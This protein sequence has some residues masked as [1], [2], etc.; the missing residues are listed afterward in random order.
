[1]LA[2]FAGKCVCG[3]RVLPGM[4]VRWDREL[5]R[6]AGCP[7]CQ[8]AAAPGR[9]HPT[10]TPASVP[11][12]PVAVLDDSELFGDDAPPPIPAEQLAALRASLPAP[13]VQTDSPAAASAAQAALD[14]LLARLDPGQRRVA[15]WSPAQGNVRVIA[16]AGSGKTTTTTALVGSVIQRGV[17]PAAQVIATTFT[18]RAGKELSERLARVL[19]P[20]QHRDLRVGTF[21]GLALRAL[22][23]SSSS[24]WAMGRCLDIGKRDHGV[25]SATKLWGMVLGW[26]EIPGIGRKGLDLGEDISARDYAQVADCLRAGLTDIDHPQAEEAARIAARAACLQKFWDAWQL[27]EEAKAAL[28]AWDFAD[29]LAEWHA[30]LSEDRMQHRAQLVVVDEAQDNSLI[31]LSIAQQLSRDGSLIIV[32]DCRQAIYE[33]RGASPDFFLTADKTIG[34]ATR[35]LLRNYRSGRKIVA[36]GNAVSA[37]QPWALGDQ[38]VAA[39]DSDGEVT[40]SHA[41]TVVA[42]AEQIAEQI[43]QHLND[44]ANP[45]S[46]AVLCRTNAQSG[47]VEAAL[48]RAQIPCAV[49]GGTSFFARR[50]VQD[51]L[52]YMLLSERDDLDALARIINRPRRFLGKAFIRAVGEK[53]GEAAGNLLL[54]VEYAS[55][56]LH[57][58]QRD[59]AGELVNTLLDLRAAR[60]KGWEEAAE[61]AATVL[62]PKEEDGASGSAD[63]DRAGIGL[64][65]VA[66]AKSFGSAVELCAYAKQCAEAV[67]AVSGEERVA[68]KVVISTVHRAKGLE[69]D[70]VWLLATRGVFPHR[71]STSPRAMAEERRLF[72]TAVTRAKND[73]VLSWSAI[74]LNEKP[75]GPSPFIDYLNDVPPPGAEEL[76]EPSPHT[77]GAMIE[78]ATQQLREALLGSGPDR[79]LLSTMDRLNL[80]NVHPAVM[81]SGELPPGEE[82][83]ANLPPAE[84]L[85]GAPTFR[86]LIGSAHGPAKTFTDAE[87]HADPAGGEGSHYVQITNT[88]MEGLLGRYLR[89]S[90]MPLDKAQ[91]YH[92][93]VWQRPLDAE[94]KVFLRVFSTIPLWEGDARPVGEDSIRVTLVYVPDKGPTVSLTAREPW[95]CRTRGWRLSLL[96]RLASLDEL[97]ESLPRC[98]RCGSVMRER[99]GPRGIFYGCVKFNEGCLG[100]RS[101]KEA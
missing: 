41:A 12:A 31:Q 95:V 10:P 83:G 70:H 54:A 57:R 99:K 60:K 13:R 62:A 47:P 21:H 24:R 27:Y 50:E 101:K 74:D 3:G 90:T 8:A 64:A 52:A 48:V 84:A 97:Y 33:W 98:P 17:I 76:P 46:C 36:L 56:D 45:A 79:A 29:A 75:A 39:R 53:M 4:T 96:E 55:E 20:S 22:R 82:E 51:V 68:G 38:A 34:A 81:L 11:E 58:G 9:A 71:R 78:N 25:P 72:Y 88:G 18:S 35:Q 100:S 5:R 16:A 19:T 91:P 7:A 73:L 59:S 28:H 67:E 32:G 92:Q 44:G 85:D 15:E 42:E 80:A 1:M 14:E 61:A 37:G 89:F 86:Q 93:R 65:L 43:Q 30:G 94:G 2:K 69:W 26:D 6:I 49:V 77:P 40:V 63:E 87:P 66:V 23:S